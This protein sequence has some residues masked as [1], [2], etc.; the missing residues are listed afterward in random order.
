M[1]LLEMTSRRFL[2]GDGQRA[3]PA[4]YPASSAATLEEALGLCEESR[5]RWRKRGSH[6]ETD[7]KMVL[8]LSVGIVHRRTNNLS[9]T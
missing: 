8:V 4:H 6:V 3:L 2:L 7:S 9:S 1:L 5:W